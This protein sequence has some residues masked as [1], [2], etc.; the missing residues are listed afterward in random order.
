M[1]QEPRTLNLTPS[2]QN[3]PE[4]PEPPPRSPPNQPPKTPPSP[5]PPKTPAS[6]KPAA[7]HPTFQPEN[8][9]PENLKT[10]LPQSTPS[11]SDK[12]SSHKPPGKPGTSADK[13][14]TP[15]PEPKYSEKTP[16][17]SEKPSKPPKHPSY[18]LFPFLKM[19]HASPFCSRS[20][21]L[22]LSLAP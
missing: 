22:P 20:P 17:I 6:D 12:E 18:P 2:A 3:T 21:P 15:V 16:A 7:A 11:P 10:L 8:L 9:Q 5:D 4:P 19:H 14:K 13:T 1:N